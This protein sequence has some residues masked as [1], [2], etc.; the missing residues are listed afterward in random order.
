MTD[1]AARVVM[2]DKFCTTSCVARAQELLSVPAVYLW[3][4]GGGTRRLPFYKVLLSNDME[5]G[6]ERGN[7]QPLGCEE[8]PRG[9][10]APM[11]LRPLAA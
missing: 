7:Q 1:E 11:I 5:P 10:A 2:V 8:V 9:G 3:Q 4:V 6:R